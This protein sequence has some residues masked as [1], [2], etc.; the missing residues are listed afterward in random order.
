MVVNPLDYFYKN[1][2]TVNYL[3]VEDASIYAYKNKEG[4]ANW[5]ILKTDTASVQ[6]SADMVVSDTVRPLTGGIDIRKCR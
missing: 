6:V 5:D 2:I 1:K 4:V 3:G